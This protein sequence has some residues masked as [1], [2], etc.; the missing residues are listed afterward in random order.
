M[1]YIDNS[2]YIIVGK[3]ISTYCIFFENV[4]D[5]LTFDIICLYDYLCYKTC[6][7]QTLNIH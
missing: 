7:I 4:Y 5:E 3:C 6:Y 1:Q 2:V